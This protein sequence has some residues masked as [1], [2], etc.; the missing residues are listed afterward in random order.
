MGSVVRFFISGLRHG[1]VLSIGGKMVLE[2]D[3]IRILRA[4]SLPSVTY[5]SDNVD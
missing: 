3:A 1:Q 5:L 2:G 4:A